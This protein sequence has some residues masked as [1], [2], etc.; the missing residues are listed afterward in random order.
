[1]YSTCSSDKSAYSARHYCDS[2]LYVDE[3]CLR[4]PR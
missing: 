3:P 4:G 2:Y 1:M